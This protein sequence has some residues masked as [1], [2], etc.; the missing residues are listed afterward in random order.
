MQFLGEAQFGGNSLAF[1]PNSGISNGCVKVFA[2]GELNAQAADRRMLIRVNGAGAGYQGFVLM[3]GHAGAGEW[4]NSGF[5][6]GRN[7]WG[8][9]ATFMLEYTLAVGPTSQKITGTGQTT[10]A[11]GNNTIVGYETHGFLVTNQPLT[12]IEVI[13]TGGV[14]A[15]PPARFYLF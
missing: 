2:T 6:S 9:D 15:G 7:G 1:T 11:H 8:Q 5:Y 10:F 14:V 3:N 13:F 4:D 12:R